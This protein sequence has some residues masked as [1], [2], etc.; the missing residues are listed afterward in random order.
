MN[1]SIGAHAH[2][3]LVFL[4]W[5]SA[6]MQDP[7]AIAIWQE[8]IN[9]ALRW[10]RSVHRTAVIERDPLRMLQ[11]PLLKREQRRP[12]GPKLM[13]KFAA[14]IR[15]IDVAHQVGGDAGRLI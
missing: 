11:S 8:D 10:I 3:E 9:H 7:P 1:R 12:I 5:P 6:Q 13:N 15:D 2:A 4:V 14:T